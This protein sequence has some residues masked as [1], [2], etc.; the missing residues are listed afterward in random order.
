MWNVDFL[1]SSMLLELPSGEF[2]LLDCG[3]G[4]MVQL[5]R[6]YPTTWKSILRRLRFVIIS[7]SH[8][9]HH[10]GLPLLLHY[11]YYY[12]MA[13]NGQQDGVDGMNGM[14]EWDGMDG[15]DKWGGMDGMDKWGGMDGMDGVWL[16]NAKYMN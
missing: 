6:L 9:D 5:L 15:M 14:N 13:R 4:M 10:L 8:A 2:A 12:G 11:Y 3:E 16:E 7:H 1:V